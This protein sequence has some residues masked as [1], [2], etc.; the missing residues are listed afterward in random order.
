MTGRASVR[1]SRLPAPWSAAESDGHVRGDGMRRRMIRLIGFLGGCSLAAGWLAG[2][3]SAADRAVDA[4]VLAPPVVFDG[5]GLDGFAGSGSIAAAL[6]D[7]DAD[8]QQPAP[9]FGMPVDVVVKGPTGRDRVT[10]ALAAEL[11]GRLVGLD[12]V[13][14]MQA[15][16]TMVEEG[17]NRWVGGLRMS[18]AHEAGRD[19]LELKTSL[20]RQ[21]QTGV[22]G[23]ELGPRIERRLRGGLTVFLDGKAQAQARRSADTG[24]WMMPGT[25]GDRGGMLGVA[26]STGLTR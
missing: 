1:Q 25:N 23:L 14:G 2:Q 20:G 12:L 6:R 4:A 5:F 17:P 7:V 19:V 22:L 10:D 3:A 8:G 18:H 24:D 11:K 21:Q 9:A 15:D 26:A 13:A 16:A